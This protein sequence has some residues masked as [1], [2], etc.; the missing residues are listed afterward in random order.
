MRY[1]N[2]NTQKVLLYFKHRSIIYQSIFRARGPSLKQ[3]YNQIRINIHCRIVSLGLLH[4][5]T[6]LLFF[7]LHKKKIG[8]FT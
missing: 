3:G 2:A 7:V 8:F 5:S 6:P 1:I 4:F